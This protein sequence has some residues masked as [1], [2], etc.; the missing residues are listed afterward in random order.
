MITSI[1][2]LVFFI[3]ILLLRIFKAINGP[4]NT[5]VLI[6]CYI[7]Y[8]VDGLGGGIVIL[9]TEFILLFDLADKKAKYKYNL[10]KSYPA[11]YIVF[12][13]FVICEGVYEMPFGI[14]IQLIR[15]KKDLN[16]YEYQQQQKEKEDDK[17]KN[18]NPNNGYNFQDT[19]ININNEETANET[20]N[21]T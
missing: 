18:E 3:T 20:H 15:F 9:V 19:N 14:D 7:I 16:Y 2:R 4:I 21:P 13:G 11:V 8:W 10:F 1:I 17:K 6:L 5:L 12:I